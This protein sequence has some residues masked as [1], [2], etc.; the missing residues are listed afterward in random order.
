MSDFEDEMDVDVPS[1]SIQFSTDGNAGKQKRVVADLPIE[2]GDNLPWYI[3]LQNFS[4]QSSNIYPGSR[5]TVLLHSKMSQVMPISWQQS[6]ASSNIIDF[7]IFSSTV[8]QVQGKHQ[9]SLLS[10][11]R[12]TAPRTC[13]RWS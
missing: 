4:S 7:P 13:V 12:Y 8:L 9:P 10:P 11:A 2:V 6:T 3:D 1:K 5:N